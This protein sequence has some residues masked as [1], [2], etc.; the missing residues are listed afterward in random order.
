VKVPLSADELARIRA[1]AEAARWAVKAWIAEAA[2]TPPVA[3]AGDAGFDERSV[4]LVELMRAGR[5]LRGIAVNLNQIARAINGVL[6]GH[7]PTGDRVAE[8]L[9]A[10]EDLPKTL[11]AVKAAQ[12]RVRDA[13]IALRTRRPRP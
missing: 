1:N 2:L 13:V 11:N 12:A 7:G 8:L 4:Q 5:Q 3:G 6:A 10:A 9:A